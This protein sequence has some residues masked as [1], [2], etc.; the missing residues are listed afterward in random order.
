MYEPS[1]IK[2]YDNIQH[3]RTTVFVADDL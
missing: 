1:L 3:I 2:F